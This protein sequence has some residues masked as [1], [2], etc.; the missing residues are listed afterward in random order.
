VGGISRRWAGQN[1]SDQSAR[2]GGD[3]AHDIRLNNIVSICNLN[4]ISPEVNYL[5]CWNVVSRQRTI[6]C[7]ASEIKGGKDCTRTSGFGLSVTLRDTITYS[8][9]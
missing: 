4:G 3:L 1:L 7:Q 8:M 2:E 5:V 6:R 9:K